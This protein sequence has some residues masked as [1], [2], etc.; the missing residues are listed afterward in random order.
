MWLDAL[1]LSSIVCPILGLNSNSAVTN[2]GCVSRK[3]RKPKLIIEC[4]VQRIL[5]LRAVSQRHRS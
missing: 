5:V 3:R 2:Q 1:M 4:I